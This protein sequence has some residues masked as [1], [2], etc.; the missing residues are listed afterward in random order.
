MAAKFN[1]WRCGTCWIH[2][3]LFPRATNSRRRSFVFFHLCLVPIQL[4]P[5]LAVIAASTTAAHYA[6]T[7]PRLKRN[8]THMDM[9]I[10]N[11]WDREPFS[12]GPSTR[13]GFTLFRLCFVPIQLTPILAVAASTTAAHWAENSPHV[14]R[15]STYGDTEPVRALFTWA[16]NTWSFH[17]LPFVLPSN[18]THSNVCCYCFYNCG[19]LGGKLPRLAPKL[20][21]WPDQTGEMILVWR[22]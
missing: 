18:S 21:T 12:L 1:I 3:A 20:Q 19:S 17:F 2:V 14:Q 9:E 11:P 6:A 7:S 16:I 13:G 22:E 5:I 4:T 15:N 8:S 10:R